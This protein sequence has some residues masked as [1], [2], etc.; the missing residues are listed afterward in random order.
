MSTIL[1][2]KLAGRTINLK[3]KDMATLSS[4]HIGTLKRLQ[5][6]PIR[7]AN[8]AAYL[9]LGTLPI[10]AELH[11]RQLSLLHQIA[12]SDNMSFPHL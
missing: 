8:S 3:K 10:S 7:T 11:K 6:L 2:K 12:M 5:S 9:L 1:M 4:F